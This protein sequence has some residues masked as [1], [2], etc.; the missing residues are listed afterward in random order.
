[1]ERRKK[2]ELLTDSEYRAACRGAEASR[3]KVHTRVSEGRRPQVCAE[4]GEVGARWADQKRSM[5]NY[6]RPGRNIISTGTMF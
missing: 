2:P 6:C 5:T 4:L 1:M 3:A